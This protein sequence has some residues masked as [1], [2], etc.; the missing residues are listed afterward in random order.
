MGFE[1]VQCD[2]CE[3]CAWSELLIGGR[4]VEFRRTLSKQETNSDTGQVESIKPS[5]DFIVYL[6]CVV[7]SLPLEHT[8][9]DSSHSGVVSPLDVLQKLCELGI[10]IPDFWRP[11]N[12]RGLRII[13]ANM[14]SARRNRNISDRLT[15]FRSESSS[16]H[17][18]GYPDLH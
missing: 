3:R 6:A 8:L 17:S 13:P 10:V 7:R 4:S 5:L 14:F 9:G 1:G 18:R 11:N 15:S 12:P 2:V 16:F